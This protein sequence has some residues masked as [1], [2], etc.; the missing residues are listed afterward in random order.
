MKRSL[1]NADIVIETNI[2]NSN[3]NYNQSYTDT[4]DKIKK[5]IITIFGTKYE[6]K[7]RSNKVL[8]NKLFIMIGWLFLSIKRLVS[9][10]CKSKIDLLFS[11]INIL[12]ILSYFF[13]LY[14]Y[15]ALNVINDC[16]DLGFQCEYIKSSCVEEYFNYSKQQ[17]DFNKLSIYDREL[18]FLKILEEC[19]YTNNYDQLKKIIWFDC[20]K[21]FIIK[22]I[23]G[24]LLYHFIFFGNYILKF[25]VQKY[26]EYIPDVMDIV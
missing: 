4:D 7:H 12:S 23:C 24:F 18:P 20:F 10:S 22:A 1:N 13:I 8:D 6:I 9:F 11:V 3:S 19:I 17:Y 25:S 26:N 5:K 21:I 15:C 2:Y 14:T 16:V